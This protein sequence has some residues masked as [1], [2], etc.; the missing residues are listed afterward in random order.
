MLL[1]SARWR[2]PPRMYFSRMWVSYYY[3]LLCGHTQFIGL[4][5][6]KQEILFV[7]TKLRGMETKLR[8]RKGRKGGKEEEREECGGEKIRGIISGICQIGSSFSAVEGERRKWLL[9]RAKRERSKREKRPIILSPFRHSR[10]PH[11]LPIYTIRTYCRAYLTTLFG[12]YPV[13]FWEQA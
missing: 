5:L 11:S 8:R 9:A 4:P 10:H 3:I 12:K 1:L 13:L 6:R 7:H 2:E